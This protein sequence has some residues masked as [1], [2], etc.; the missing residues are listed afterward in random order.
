MLAAA[1]ANSA[2]TSVT[3]QPFIRNALPAILRD[4]RLNHFKVSDFALQ[5]SLLLEPLYRTRSGRV[6]RVSRFC[7]RNKATLK[8]RISLAR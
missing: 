8:L 7:A 6:C 4:D 5:C 3:L 2:A 1:S